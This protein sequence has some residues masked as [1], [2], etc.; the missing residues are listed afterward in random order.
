MRVEAR[1]TGDLEKFLDALEMT[2]AF[3]NVLPTD[4]Q[5]TSTTGCS[6]R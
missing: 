5:A 6:R 1:Q 3:H 4:E 2:G